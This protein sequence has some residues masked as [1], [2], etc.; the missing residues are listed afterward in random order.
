MQVSTTLERFCETYRTE[1]RGAE[2]ES[3]RKLLGLDEESEDDQG[4]QGDGN[5]VED[6]DSESEDDDDDEAVVVQ[7]RTCRAR[8][9]RPNCRY[10]QWILVFSYSFCWKKIGSDI[11][12]N[13]ISAILVLPLN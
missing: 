3:T 12:L 9:V 4:W 7:A 10:E 6:E 5:E 2:S 8:E 11:V 1:T 13:T